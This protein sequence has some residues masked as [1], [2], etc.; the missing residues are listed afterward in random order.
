MLL[1]AL[2]L[3]PNYH[4]AVSNWREEDEEEQENGEM[5]AFLKSGLVIVHRAFF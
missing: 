2:E 4:Y 1:V 5:R 3:L